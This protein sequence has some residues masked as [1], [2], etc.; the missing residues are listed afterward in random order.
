M[1]YQWRHICGIDDV[2]PDSLLSCSTSVWSWCIWRRYHWTCHYEALLQ[3]YIN[4]DQQAHA[5][6]R[7]GSLVAGSSD[8]ST[9]GKQRLLYHT[10]IMCCNLKYNYCRGRLRGKREWE[11][12]FGRWGSRVCI[13][14][15]AG[16]SAATTVGGDFGPGLMA[17][18]IYI[19][20]LWTNAYRPAKSPILLL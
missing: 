3:C 5:S 9:T 15:Q 19:T 13:Q 4:T 11:Q 16:H 1:W 8:H 2:T 6:T 12:W 18:I 14:E 17:Q 20:W 10:R 7:G